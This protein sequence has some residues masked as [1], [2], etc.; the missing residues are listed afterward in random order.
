MSDI[1]DQVAA[2][3]AEL[4]GAAVIDLH[5]IQT[6]STLLAHRIAAAPTH[7]LA[8]V[9]LREFIEARPDQRDYGRAV[10]VGALG[11]LGQYVML[12]HDLRDFD[13]ADGIL[14]R[15]KRVS[16]AARGLDLPVFAVRNMGSV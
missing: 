7:E 5:Q 15:L 12:F 10:A 8:A 14:A 4:D 9:E 1:D 11:V 6:D 3:A 13:G 2:F 16:F